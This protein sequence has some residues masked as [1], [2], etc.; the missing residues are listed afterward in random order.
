MDELATFWQVL[1]AICAGIVSIGGA[2]AVISR[3]WQ[4]KRDLERVVEQH[5]RRL[6]STH[7]DVAALI[8][9]Q[10]IQNRCMLQLLNHT[11]D[12]NHTGQL[13]AERDALQTYLIEK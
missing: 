4:P 10:R 3:L 1:L 7:E 2:L 9:G 6:A 8:E 12:G 13:I 5:E 11:I